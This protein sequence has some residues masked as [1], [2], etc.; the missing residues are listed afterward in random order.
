[1]DAFATIIVPVLND[2]AAL[3]LWL[4]AGARSPGVE[5]IVVSG[6]PLDGALSDVATAHPEIA[7]IV[8]PPGRG[9]QMNAGAEA[10]RGRW[11]LFVHAD[12]LLPEEW[13]SE[14]VRADARGA[15]GGF[16]RF[17][18]ASR[19][20]AARV[21]ERGVAWRIRWLSLPYGDQALFVRRDVF[22][23]LGGFR[24]WPLMEDVDLV[25]RL[26]REGPLWAS[27]KSVLVSAR[28]WE[29]DGW[30][31]RSAENALLL[32]AYFAGVPPARLARR[33]YRARGEGRLA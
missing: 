11:L 30:W 27:D 18:L 5:V 16:F 14:L 7:W 6:A 3:R 26:R 25:R 17:A 24:P 20:R 1:M 8:S 21:I 31:T 4:A 19:A 33:Y 10:A 23:R 12:V 2:A 28:R 29:R 22:G 32:A 15:V 9:L 13:P